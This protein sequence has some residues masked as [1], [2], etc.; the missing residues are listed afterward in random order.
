MRSMLVIRIS[1]SWWE[2]VLGA[3]EGV[4]RYLPVSQ[5]LN[6]EQRRDLKS[7]WRSLNISRPRPLTLAG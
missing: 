3:T 6:P 2:L 4:T 7:S 1:Q 5:T